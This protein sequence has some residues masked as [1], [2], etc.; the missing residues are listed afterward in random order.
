MWL[1]GDVHQKYEQ[2]LNTM[3]NKEETIQLGDFGFDYSVLIEEEIDPNKHR[4]LL[5]NHDNPDLAKQYP[6][7]LGDFGIV[8]ASSFGSR[9]AFYVRGADSID[10]IFRREGFD[11]FSN[12]ELNYTQSIECMDFWEAN[13]TNVVLTHD[14]PQWL[15]NGIWGYSPSHTRKLLNEIW[16]IHRPEVWVFGHHH[17]RIDITIE[18]CRF[19]CLG[20]LET[21]KV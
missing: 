12:E 14:C 3:W 21:L 4:I 18:G 6:H 11:W 7:F 16:N 1:I 19:V 17:K 13:K 10:R 9:G 8:H 15:A 5:G 2:Y 20:E